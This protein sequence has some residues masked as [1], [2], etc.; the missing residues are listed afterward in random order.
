[1]SQTVQY[2]INDSLNKKKRIEVQQVNLNLIRRWVKLAHTFGRFPVSLNEDKRNHGTVYCF[3]RGK[4]L[5]FLIP[6]WTGSM[7]DDNT[8][9]SFVS[10][11]LSRVIQVIPQM[12]KS[13]KSTHSWPSPSVKNNQHKIESLLFSFAPF[14]L[15]RPKTN[16]LDFYVTARSRFQSCSV[17]SR[18]MSCNSVTLEF[19]DNSIAIYALK[20]SVTPTF[21]SR[22][23]FYLQLSLHCPKMN[24]K[25]MC[26]DQKKKSRF[27]SARHRILPSCG[28]KVREIVVAKWELV[29]WGTS[30]VD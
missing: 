30:P 1:M 5:T 20:S 27:L 4:F 28:F 7:N 12:S 18:D 19:D 15:N 3:P 9:V 10:Q 22:N 17:M 21:L 25:S 14:S 29:N 2:K 16:A 6:P 26:E 24:K 23:T 11:R 13:C 8:K